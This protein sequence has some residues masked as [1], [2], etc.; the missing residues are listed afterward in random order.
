MKH[1]TEWMHRLAILAA[2]AFLP[3]CGSQAGVG[4]QGEVETEAHVPATPGDALPSS[5]P[6][7]E[8]QTRAPA[9]DDEKA[10][11]FVRRLSA[12]G[13]GLAWAG[14]YQS[15]PQA[16]VE[17]MVGHGL[18]LE[19]VEDEYDYD[20]AGDDGLQHCGS[21]RVHELEVD[22]CFVQLNGVR[23]L[24]SIHLPLADR[25]L[26]AS[27]KVT[28]LSEG[29]IDELAA[30]AR[31]QIPD[32]KAECPSCALRRGAQMISIG[33]IGVS[34]RVPVDFDSDYSGMDD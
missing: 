3:A 13:Q 27:G 19:A 10:R 11:A 33:P 5:M 34:V 9:T 14:L 6:A 22:L 31:R 26:L 8:Q 12:H 18:K 32:L 16:Q 20:V 29:Q 4:A 24:F 23:E 2:L 30:M 25:D 17:Q 7:A 15:M 28:G 1:E 21:T